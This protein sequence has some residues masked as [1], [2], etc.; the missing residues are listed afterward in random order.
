M[1]TRSEAPHYSGIIDCRA[2]S[3]RLRGLTASMG[4]RDDW[5]TP[6]PSLRLA[7]IGQARIPPAE[8]AR[9]CATLYEG[10]SHEQLAPVAEMILRDP[11]VSAALDGWEM[12]GCCHVH[13]NDRASPGD[14]HCDDY[15]GQPWPES[16]RRMILCYFPQD[17]TPDMG[18]T[19][20]LIDGQVVSAAGPA[21]TFV[22][23]GHDM[24]HRAGANV[25]GRRRL[26]VK[27]LVQELRR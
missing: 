17:T 10:M 25:S 5:L 19:E 6:R 8:N 24:L 4:C 15:C 11:V 23:M 18:P 27:V 13:E 14:W 2:G 20:L 3:P 22:L 9:L 26:M 16:P 7:L 12:D 21:G 1:P